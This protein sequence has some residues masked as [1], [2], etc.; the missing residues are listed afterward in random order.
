MSELEKI[1]YRKRA[2]TFYKAGIYSTAFQILAVNW[3]QRRD[4]RSFLYLGWMLLCGQGCQKNYKMATRIFKRL[5]HDY[6]TSESVEASKFL[7]FAYCNKN[8]EHLDTLLSGWCFE[9][10]PILDIN[11]EQSF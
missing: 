6:Q 5:I 7:V 4:P 9:N 1:Y 3:Y 8:V 10:S 11:L 2:V